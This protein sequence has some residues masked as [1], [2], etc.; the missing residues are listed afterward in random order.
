[1]IDRIVS[2]ASKER[3][4]PAAGQGSRQ[5]AWH[6]MGALHCTA[7]HVRQPTGSR[8]QIPDQIPDPDH[9]PDQIPD[10]DHD[11]D[12]IPDQDHDPDQ[13]P[14]PGPRSRSDSRSGPRSRSSLGLRYTVY[15]G[16]L[17]RTV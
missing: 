9:D 4:T 5:H 13:I 6:G 12:Q 17:N 15:R 10:P 14:D 3:Q 1:M 7:L 2:C 8:I 16:V 11:P